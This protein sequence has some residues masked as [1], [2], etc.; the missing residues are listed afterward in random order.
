M[1]Y[2][3][4]VQKDYPDS[5]YYT[6]RALAGQKRKGRNLANHRLNQYDV[7]GLRIGDVIEVREVTVMYSSWGS[8]SYNALRPVR[9]VGRLKSLKPFI[10]RKPSNMFN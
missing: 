10:P 1:S 3:F 9:R 4:C 8:P 2:Y 5:T 6:L 7:K